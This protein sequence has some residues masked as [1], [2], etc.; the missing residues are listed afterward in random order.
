MRASSSPNRC[1]PRSATGADVFVSRRA[2]AGTSSLLTL[3]SSSACRSSC[4]PSRSWS[5]STAGAASGTGCTG[6]F[7]GGLGGLVVIRLLGDAGLP[8]CSPCCW[9]SSAA[10]PCWLGDLAGGSAPD[11]WLQLLGV[12][13]LLLGAWFLFTEP[14][15]GLLTDADVGRRRGRRRSTTRPRS[16][17]WCSTSSPLASILDDDDRIDAEQFPNLALL[18]QDA[19]W[20]RNATG[21]SP[22]TPEA[23]PADP[24]RPLQRGRRAPAH[25]RGAPRQP[26]HAAA[27]H[28]R[29]PRPGVGDPALPGRPVRRGLA[30]HR[31]PA[32]GADP[33]RPRPLA[34][35]ALRRGRRPRRRL[36]HPPVR[37]RR[38]DHD[39][40]VGRRHPARAA[41]GPSWTS[42]T[43][44][45]PTSPGT[46]CRP[47]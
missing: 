47:G 44:S 35:P 9:P 7:L 46:T 16:C 4:S 10:S 36:R 21:V 33:R 39:R 40:R 1:S 43:P 38:P 26:L 31:Q 24:H 19:T 25:R 5:A 23:V 28:L 20:F 27:G 8:G 2:E 11:S 15:R 30:G 18:A 29:P 22:T 6:C 37:P 14:V 3:W 45:T 17:W 32:A 12:F 13:P 41:T 34:A 42:S